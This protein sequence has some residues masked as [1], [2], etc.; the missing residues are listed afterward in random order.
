MQKNKESAVLPPQGLI[1][2]M[3]L[4]MVFMGLSSWYGPWV[5]LLALFVIC[6]FISPAF[7]TERNLINI[8]KQ[9][10]VLGIVSVGQTL[11][12]IS[13]GFDMSVSS[14]MSFCSIIPG[15]LMEGKNTMLVPSIL[16]AFVLAI[17]LGVVN[18]FFVTKMRIH[19][20][21][22]TLATKVSLQGVLLLTTGGAPYSRLTPTYRWF[23]IGQI[24]PLPIPVIIFLL[25]AVSAA[26]ILQ[27]SA[28]GRALFA[29]GSNDQ[30]AHMSGINVDRTRFWGY[31]LCSCT[32]ALAGLVLTAR[33]GSGDVWSGRDYDLNSI[34]AVA[35]GGTRLGGGQG[36]IGR[37]IA[38][39]LILTI[40]MNIMNL[41]SVTYE[42]SLVARGAVIIVASMIYSRRT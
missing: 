21:I 39:V 17:I 14:L 37:T 25:L 24:G 26:I 3:N 15:I 16:L 42:S 5:I 40:L 29:V 23:G 8:F 28:F 36:G 1:E 27:H 35:V 2:R 30:N 10:T 33:T 34:A 9:A 38:G 32:A 4:Q 6:S 18:G 20:F 22:V 13:G 12:I 11:V 7:L 19:G 41:V 31:G